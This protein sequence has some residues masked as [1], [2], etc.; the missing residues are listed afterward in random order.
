MPKPGSTAWISSAAMM[1]STLDIPPPPY[2]AGSMDQAMPRRQA[3]SYA[4]FASCHPAYGSGSASI[5]GAS[6]A[7]TSCAKS[8][9]S[10]WIPFC[11]FVRV[12]SI[13]ILCSLS[14]LLVHC[15][16]LT[17]RARTVA[18]DRELSPD[19]ELR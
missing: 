4:G 3:S 6:G 15:A 13:A 18:S 1:K 12:K 5:F 19:N 16:R 2:A 14:S 17:R 9:A 8:R 10:P 7:S 11:S